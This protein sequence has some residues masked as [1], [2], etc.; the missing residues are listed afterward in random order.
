MFI[1]NDFI[2]LEAQQSLFFKRSFMHKKKEDAVVIGR[3]LFF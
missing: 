3:L 2:N 1:N